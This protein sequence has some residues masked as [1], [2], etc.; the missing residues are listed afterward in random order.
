MLNPFLEE[1]EIIEQNI[2]EKQENQGEQI[3]I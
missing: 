1:H 3:E 2:E